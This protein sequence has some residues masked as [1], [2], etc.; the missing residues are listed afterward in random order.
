[1][2]DV[3]SRRQPTKRLFGNRSS[4]EASVGVGEELELFW[5]TARS[6]VCCAVLI[7]AG[8][9]GAL[10]QMDTCFSMTIIIGTP[11]PDLADSLLG[12]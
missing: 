6:L 1:M 2:L 7:S 9:I 11:F 12:G 4:S 3:G 8:R 5:M 10:I